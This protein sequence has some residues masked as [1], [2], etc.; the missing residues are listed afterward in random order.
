[1]RLNYGEDNGVSLA[2]RTSQSSDR[3]VLNVT[4]CRTFLRSIF[5]VITRVGGSIARISQVATAD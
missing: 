1:M 4:V 2:R 5:T 3:I